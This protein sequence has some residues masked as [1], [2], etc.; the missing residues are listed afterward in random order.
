MD[1]F[2]ALPTPQKLLIGFLGLAVVG[3]GCY[4]LLIGDAEAAITAAKNKIRK[5]E[6]QIQQLKKYESGELLR[7]LEAEEAELQ[8]QLAANK[9]LLPEEEKVPALITSIK[10]QAD[11]RGLK[12]NLF[13]RKDKYPDDYVELIPVEMEV[14]GSFPVVVSFFEALAQPGMRMMT[15][16]GLDIESLDVKSIMDERRVEQQTATL[17]STGVRAGQKVEKKNMTPTEIFLA[18]LDAYDGAVERMRVKAKFVVNA[19]SYTGELL[20]A[21]QRKQRKKRRR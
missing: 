17:T 8:E 15:V 3:G 6:Q 13:K 20:T 14:E 2:E 10:R 7:A 12:I 4:F 5:A 18:K 1:R 21:E 9:A 11:E 19:Y 16:S